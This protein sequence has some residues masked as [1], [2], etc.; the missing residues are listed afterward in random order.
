MY[1]KTV[2]DLDEART[3]SLEEYERVLA[4]NQALARRTSRSVATLGF[5]L[6]AVSV[7]S[8]ML[9]GAIAWLFPYDP[10]AEERAAAL[11]AY[12][13]RIHRVLHDLKQPAALLLHAI[14]EPCIDRDLVSAITTQLT[15][16]LHSIIRPDG[17]IARQYQAI[18]LREFVGRLHRAHS[19]LFAARDVQL[20]C[21]LSGVPDDA[22]VLLVPQDDLSRALENFLSNANK[23]VPDGGDVVVRA[24]ATPL[25][26]GEFLVEIEVADTGKGL[27]DA[28][29]AA[30][31]RDPD[32]NGPEAGFGLLGLGL[33]LG[34][35][36]VKR[37]AEQEGGR[38]WCK[39]N[40]DEAHGAVFG[41]AIKA[42][43]MAKSSEISF[44]SD[45]DVHVAI[46]EE[47]GVQATAGADLPVGPLRSTRDR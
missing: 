43:E 30:S 14:A 46:P 26:D 17:N 34:L 19:R 2:L 21:D 24:R 5:V 33:G 35:S 22:P 42:S 41:L 37:F 11:E 45:L 40:P 8:V 3:A 15:T 10:S 27:P 6:G 7:L 47:T 12:H 23:F 44:A 20:R 38:V 13:L 32:V 31:L 29:S 39:N 36:G 16:R 28:V 4:R 18:D 9:V 25:Q 1:Y